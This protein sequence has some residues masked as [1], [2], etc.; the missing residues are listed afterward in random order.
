MILLLSDWRKYPRAIIDERTSNESFLRMARLYK[1]MGIKNNAFHLSLLQP[2]LQG[3]DPHDPRLS[4]ELMALIRMECTYNPWYFFREVV[5]LPAMAGSQARPL[6][7]NRGNIALWWAF[8]NHIDSGLIQPRQT[9]K[10]V[11]TDVMMDWV[12]YLGAMNTKV[13]MITKDDML[14]QANIER[15]KNIRDLMPPYLYIKHPDDR[16]NQ[17]EMT[18]EALKNIYLTGVAQNSENGANNLGRGLTSPI[19][20]VDEGP[21]ISYI[22]TTIP[23]ALAAG[24]AAR[25]EAAENNRPY[26]NIF[27]TTAGKKD[28]RDGQYMYR[29]ITNGA[30]MNEIYY[31]AASPKDL[32]E[33]I[34]RNGSGRKVFLNITM[35]HRQLG[36]TDEWLYKT[37]VDNE[38]TGEVADR[39]FLNIWT[40]GT[41]RSPLSPKLN[42]MILNSEK[43]IVWSEISPDNYILR[44]YITP[45][46]AKARMAERQ[47][48]IGIDTSD[49][50]GRDS[51]ALI[52]T[53]SHDLS[54]VAAGTYNE[55]NLIRWAMYLLSLLVK[56][57]NTTAII[58]R[59]STAATIIDLLLIRLPRMGHDPFRRLFNRVVDEHSERKIEYGEINRRA[60]NRS[61][62][63]YDSYKRYFG[64]VTN[65]ENRPLLFTTVLQNAA[66]R[67][68]HLVADKTLSGEIRG[69]VEKKGRIDHA[70]GSNDDHVIAWLLCHWFLTHGRNLS[71][72]GIDVSTLMSGVQGNMDIELTAEEMYQKQEQDL[73]MEEFNALA[74]RLTESNDPIT[75]AK[76]EHRLR[77]L[78]SRLQEGQIDAE[79][80]IDAM[81]HK[82]SEERARRQRSQY[83]LRRI[84]LR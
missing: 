76:I 35:S 75:A 21:F 55:T 27:T 59:K 67:S 82:A 78:S 49:A 68:G 36:Y 64:Y 83:G 71:H 70:N 1:S 51:I 2:E 50:V 61:E 12:I 28:D 53:D 30:V 8:L 43:D 54:V 13:I 47:F 16:D 77:V 34:S 66:K 74:E 11:S 56:Y 22:G 20:H 38:A 52:I 26:G 73:V 37:I 9:G 3:V 58:E 7:A 60:D 4:P 81:I 5:R 18:C 19:L 42:E 14:R 44:W 17:K 31:D 33:M 25:E 40:S 79:F 29:M 10:S 23:A 69:L 39:D 48:I 6:R 32:R 46:E 63:F 15:L 72:Y 24:T 57:P 62:T 41:Q 80:S 45:E 84:G 65:A